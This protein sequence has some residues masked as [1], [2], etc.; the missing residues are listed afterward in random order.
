LR[1]GWGTF[2]SSWHAPVTKDARPTARG[3]KKREECIALQLLCPTVYMYCLPQLERE[4]RSAQM[5]WRESGANWRTSKAIYLYSLLLL[6][7]PPKKRKPKEVE[8]Q[9]QYSLFIGKSLFTILGAQESIG[10][11]CVSTTN[12]W[13]A[14]A[15]TG[16][17]KK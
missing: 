2:G 12:N 4:R 13:E 6:P 7:F 10:F 11:C 16:P 14:Y 9:A 8:E 17:R 3:V 15:P 5:D 1:V